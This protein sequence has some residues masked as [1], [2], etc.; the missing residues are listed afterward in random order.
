MNVLVDKRPRNFKKKQSWEDK[1]DFDL[2]VEM[3]LILESVVDD[4]FAQMKENEGE[5]VG[6]YVEVSHFGKKTNAGNI[7][8]TDRRF[9]SD[10][11][12]KLTKGFLVPLQTN[13]F[14]QIRVHQQFVWNMCGY[15]MLYNAYQVVKFY[16]TGKSLYLKQMLTTP[17]QSNANFWR[18][19]HQMSSVLRRW[20]RKH[21]KQKDQLWNDKW[22]LTGDLER[23]HLVV[24][25]T[26]SNLIRAAFMTNPAMYSR[27]RRLA[28]KKEYQ[29][30]FGIYQ[31]LIR[32]PPNTRTNVQHRLQLFTTAAAISQRS[33]PPHQ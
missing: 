13:S 30:M 15:H 31:E 28:Q 21:K 17:R 19:K 9:V 16:R 33:L 3:K 27:I 6:K 2:I 1:Y 7:I 32:R 29:N 18:F 20:A 5:R 12:K 14:C 11:Y 4:L 8:D 25:L 22:C 26:E 10:F 23:N 24:L